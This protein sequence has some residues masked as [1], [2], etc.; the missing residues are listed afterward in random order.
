[1]SDEQ[2]PTPIDELVNR[3]AN[4]IGQLTTENEWLRVQLELAQAQ[5]QDKANPMTNGEAQ[6]A[7]HGSG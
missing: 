2:T 5:Q 4:R 1:M 7:V 6:E 3:L